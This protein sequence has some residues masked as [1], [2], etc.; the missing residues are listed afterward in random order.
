VNQQRVPAMRSLSSGE[1]LEG[2]LRPEAEQ[3]W[4]TGEIT[5]VQKK[6]LN[7]FLNGPWLPA[8]P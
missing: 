7:L 4:L 8:Y 5:A 6:I 1:L 2:D 3:L